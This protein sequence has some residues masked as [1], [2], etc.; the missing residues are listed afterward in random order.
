[1][2]HHP[3]SGPQRSDTDPLFSSRITDR[4]LSAGPLESVARPPALTAEQW[5]SYRELGYFIAADAVSPHLLGE[6]QAA[7]RR[8]RDRIRGGSLRHGYHQRSPGAS[9]DDGDWQAWSVRGVYTPEFGEP[10]FGQWQASDELRR[11]T[12]A[13]LDCDEDEIV[14]GD[15]ALFIQ[16][17]DAD[18]S[19][20]WHQVRSS[21]PPP[22]PPPSPGSVF[23]DSG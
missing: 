18:F 13:L 23:G 3:N 21:P 17:T 1:M 19:A 20:G 5:E 22:A 7:A 8:L 12:T 10:C 11:Y 6:M 9:A 2:A 15:C 14:L 4:P 16:P